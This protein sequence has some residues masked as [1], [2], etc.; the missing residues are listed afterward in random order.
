VVEDQKPERD[1]SAR[2]SPSE[3]RFIKLGKGGMWE[4]GCIEGSPP[5]LQFGFNSPCH[6]ACLSGDWQSV[7]AYWREEAP[8]EAT[9][10]VNQIKD[11]YTLG[12]DALWITFYK[13]KL[14]WCMA[15]PEVVELTPGGSRIRRALNGWRYTDLAGHT[16]FTDGLSGRLTQVQGFRGTIC[17]VHERDY[18]LSRLNGDVL[19]DVQTAS[20]DLAALK[21]S[22][23]PLIQRLNWKDFELLVDLIFSRAG[24]QRLS[25]LGKTE[26]S[27]DLELMLPV[28]GDRAFVQVKSAATLQDLRDYVAAYRK[29]EQLQQMFFVVHTANTDLY[30]YARQ[31]GVTVMG[32]TELAAFVVDSGLTQWLIQKAS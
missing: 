28:T 25:P 32:L 8:G 1:A 29:T 16:L 14:Y 13:R 12:A 22:V 9:K 19:P 17:R 7:E 21:R 27:I 11:F 26:K 30:E 20:E 4:E 5:T 23:M 24:W 31:E 6:Q 10:I 18:L 3:V 15:D 2:I